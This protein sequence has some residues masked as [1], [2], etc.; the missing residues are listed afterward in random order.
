[1]AKFRA[2][3]VLDKNTGKYYIE[4]YY[5]DDSSEPLVTTEAIYSSHEIAEQETIRMIQE[6]LPNQ[7]VKKS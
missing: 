1:M 4:L 5:P 6:A 3:S 2:E 7:P